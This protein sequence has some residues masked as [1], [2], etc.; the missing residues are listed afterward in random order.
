M[1]PA[2]VRHSFKAMVLNYSQPLI[3]CELIGNIKR[4]SS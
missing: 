3:Y 1:L 2:N 4:D